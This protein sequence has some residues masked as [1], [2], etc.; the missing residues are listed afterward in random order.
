MHA[1]MPGAQQQAQRRHVLPV[2]QGPVCCLTGLGGCMS[3]A[4]RL[5][6]TQ[7]SWTRLDSSW[8]LAQVK[9]AQ[10][11]RALD[12]HAPVAVIDAGA[13][14]WT[15]LFATA[16]WHAVTGEPCTLSRQGMPESLSQRTAARCSAAPHAMHL[17]G[18]VRVPGQT[19]CWMCPVCRPDW[20]GA[21]AGRQLREVESRSIWELCQ[22]QREAASMLAWQVTTRPSFHRLLPGSQAQAR[23]QIRLAPGSSAAGHMSV[24]SEQSP[25]TWRG[26]VAGYRAAHAPQARDSAAQGTCFQVPVKCS[27]QPG[28]LQFTCAPRLCC[29]CRPMHACNPQQGLYLGVGRLPARGAQGAE[30]GAQL[31]HTEKHTDINGTCLVLVH[32]AC[33]HPRTGQDE[34]CGLHQP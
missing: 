6:A 29:R 27:G 25:A 16:A 8:L 21:G 34:A 15:V 19:G 13:A 26:A 17:L 33:L 20:R 18:W 5:A 30:Q 22:P 14:A 9:A 11:R 28:T 1:C 2:E 32:A 24:C 23:S 7:C 12:A 3:G 4:G 10:N 31:E